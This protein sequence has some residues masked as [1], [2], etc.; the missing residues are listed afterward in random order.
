M[1]HHTIHSLFSVTEVELIYR[2][3]VNPC[4]RPIVKTSSSA[5]DV[6]LNAW[7]MNKIELQ[8]EFLILLLDRSNHCLG[9]SKIS[10]GGVSSCLIDPKIIFATSLKSR[11]SGIILAHN[12]PSGVLQPSKADIDLTHKLREGG[13]LLEISVLDHLIVTPHNYYSF[14]DE[15]MM[16]S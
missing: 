10:Q 1:E 8:E 14:T 6:L 13:K 5:Y 11:A 9:I 7:D 12:H 3:E 16:P 2:N 4:D 15:G